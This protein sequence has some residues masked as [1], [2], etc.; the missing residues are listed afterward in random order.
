VV[1]GGNYSIITTLNTGDFL[2]SLDGNS[3]QPNNT[4]YDVEGGFYT[5]YVKQANC[6]NTVTSTYLHFYIPK[7]FTPN[8]DGVK[9]TFSLS[10]IE[11]YNALQV[12]IFNRYGKLQEMLYF[13]GMVH[14]LDNFYH[15]MIIGMLLLFKIRNL[16][17]I[18]L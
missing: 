8:N 4:F 7:F 9:D 10:G 17:V 15:L 3:F 11:F 5:I 18:L 1:S 12:S 14:V 13:L 6:S 16:Q 2:Y